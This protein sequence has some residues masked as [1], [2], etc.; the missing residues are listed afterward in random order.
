MRHNKQLLIRGG[1]GLGD[2]LYVQ[3]V[4]R[5]FV[6]QG[7]TVGVASDYGD[8]FL[9]LRGKVEVSQFS[10]RGPNVIAH[11]TARRLSGG[12]TQWQ[13]V[14]ASAGIPKITPLKL[15]WSITCPE[16]VNELHARS[17][18][19]PN[20]VVQMPR[21]PMNRED[22]FALELLPNR[23][24]MQSIIYSLKS[25]AHIVQIGKGRSLYDLDGIDWDLG[26]ATTVAQMIDVVY[27][28]D[29]CL[30]YVS[31]MVPLAESLG[32]RAVFVWSMKGLDSRNAYIRAIRPE[33]ILHRP[34]LHKWVLDKY[35]VADDTYTLCADVLVGTTSPQDKFTH[36]DLSAAQN[37]V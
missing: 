27:T 25:R 8:V 2:A 6:E 32:K 4:A 19:R 37:V 34:D 10:R 35:P 15:D 3:G 20:V 1:R 18:G 29:A 31:F 36:S 5:Y 12:T 28:A 7:H 22:G 21:Y 24:A 16:L 30:G 26:N 9:P 23:E 33:K 11:Y 13:D 17:S 14:C